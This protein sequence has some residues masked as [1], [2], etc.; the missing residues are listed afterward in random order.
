MQV[1]TKRMEMVS[2]VKSH[3]SFLQKMMMRKTPRH[4][5]LFM[6]ALPWSVLTEMVEARMV[7]RFA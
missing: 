3:W 1:S 7:L 2:A 4:T 6:M 5:V